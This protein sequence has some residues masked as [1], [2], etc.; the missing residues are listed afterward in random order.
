MMKWKA[1]KAAFPYTIPIFAGFIFLGMAYGIYMNT[2]GFS[3]VYPMLIA[4]TVFGGS[5]EFVMVTLLLGTF[6][7]ISALILTLLIQARHLFYGISMLDRFRNI[8]WKKPFL[9]F[10]MC[11][12]TFS[13]NY[14]LTV[15]K[16]VDRGWFM[17]FISILN[18]SY[19]ILGATL[20]G[21]LGTFIP[22]DTTGISFVMTS[23][24]IVIFMDQWEKDAHHHAA[25]I[26]LGVSAICLIIFG[27]KAFMIPTMLTIVG[28]LAIFRKPFERIEKAV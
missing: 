26:G 22:F 19:W 11:D 25:W 20:G 3:F 9:I 7:P 21:L 17:F 27:A 12:E 6:S 23:M 14:T 8:G 18:H 4:A 5:L 28:L 10:W 1:L 16:N 24:F 15:P 2:A 13:L